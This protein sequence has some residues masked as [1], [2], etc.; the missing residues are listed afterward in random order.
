MSRFAIEA[1]FTA[2]DRMTAPVT[3]MEKATRGLAT[4]M[5]AD[6]A[7]VQSKLSN[8]GKST[9][10]FLYD[11]LA[12]GI[13]GAG[14]AL[15]Y[16][17]VRGLKLA[18]DLEEVQNVV[19]TTFGDEGQ[20]NIN[21]WS[22][23]ALKNFGL[24]ELQAKNYTSTLGSMAKSSGISGLKLQEMSMTLAGL[25]GDYASF[26]NLKP[27][28]AFEK[29]KSV[30][31]GE[32]E[33]LRQLG[34]NMTVANLEA[35]ALTRGINKQWKAMSQAEQVLLRYNYVLAN[36]KDAQ[37]DFSK[38]FDKSFAN[39]MR[40][41][42]AT[43]DQTA[44]KIMTALLPAA[45]EGVKALNEFVSTIDSKKV[46]ES[47][48]SGLD[49]LI[50]F[51]KFL[52]DMRD[53][54]KV[55]IELWIVYKA[56]Q[57]AA[58][59]FGIIKTVVEWTQAIFTMGTTLDSLIGTTEAMTA[60]QTKLNTAMSANVITIIIFAIVLLVSWITVA[61]K[62]W[63]DFGAAMLAA[64]GPVGWIV[65]YIMMISDYWTSIT[66]AFSTGGILAGLKQIGLMLLDT[67]L[68]PLQQI[69]EIASSI[70]GIGSYAASG[71]ESLKAFRS[72]TGMIGGRREVATQ[73]QQVAS[74]INTNR[75]NTLNTTNT[76]VRDLRIVVDNKAGNSIDI[77]NPLNQGV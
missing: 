41:F 32:T 54:I 59:S 29:M 74:A 58:F 72:E 27:D 2:I 51:V 23:S 40:V 37:G 61:I 26:R 15:G 14:I 48:K 60:A 42:T 56:V 50:S 18:S 45:L 67:I 4:G 47:L 24:T 36:S 6:F 52:W 22:E 69:L 25:A 73:S 19:K 43:V 77:F 8:F 68:Y 33:P 34:L 70:P 46:G 1:T 10:N 39:Q 49:S 55:L 38:T 76:Q 9:K 63:E 53:I 11:N 13:T 5:R 75:T 65:E 12:Y 62:N 44:A 16:L 28:E 30:I 57:M 71:A 66:D 31:T 20:K 21:Q 35:F 7:M 17:A 64:I 3:Q